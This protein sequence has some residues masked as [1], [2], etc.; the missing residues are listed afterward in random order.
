MNRDFGEALVDKKTP[1]IFVFSLVS[2]TLE[3]VHGL[4]ADLY[5]QYPVFDHTSTS[6]VFSGVKSPYFKLGLIYCTNR[7]MQLYHIKQPLYKK[8]TKEGEN[9]PPEDYL[10][11]ITPEG[12]YLAM[13]PRFSKDYSK[14]AYIGSDAKFLS[15]TG[16]YQLKEIAWQAEDGELDGYA[17]P[18]T[19]LDKVKEY[20]TDE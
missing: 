10:R 11:Q 18:V 17:R 4:A 20:P 15:H 9:A 2:N 7:P 14:L 19:V 1:A 12:D 16:N 6:I 5:P 8:A 13:Q 3:Q